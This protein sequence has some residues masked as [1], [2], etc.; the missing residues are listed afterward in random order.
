MKTQPSTVL[1]LVLLTTGLAH[2]EPPPMTPRECADAAVHGQKARRDGALRAASDDF[3]RCAQPTCPTVIQRDCT[4]W[5]AAVRS[6]T[7]VVRLALPKGETAK[8]LEVDARTVPMDTFV[9]LDLGAHIYSVQLGTQT[10]Q[11]TVTTARG[12]QPQSIVIQRAFPGP[13]PTAHVGRSGAG[14]G[15]AVLGLGALG[16]GILR[17]LQTQSEARAA[18]AMCA[19]ACAASELNSRQN[20]ATTWG[21]VAGSGALATVLGLG[22]ILWP[23]RP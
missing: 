7:P 5:L 10:I 1:T 20:D 18:L 3:L 8:K 9:P 19:P 2:A 12:Q 14:F 23:S 15:I 22:L 13:Q 21:I 16:V 4:V 6:E 17:A 11:G